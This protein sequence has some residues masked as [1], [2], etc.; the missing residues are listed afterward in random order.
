MNETKTSQSSRRH[1]LQGGAT[2]AG[3]AIAANAIATPPAVHAA[4]SDIL[5]VGLV[6]CGGRGTGAANNALHADPHVKLV[7]V[8]DAFRGQAENC[9]RNLKNSTTIADK[10]TVDADHVFVGLDAYQA[11]IDTVDVV[12]LCSP[13]GFRPKH[14]RAAV[15]AGCHI[16]TEKPMA[17]DSPGVRSVIES[18]KLSKEKNLSV[19]AGFCWRYSSPKL[20]FFD[21]IHAGEIGDVRASYGTYLGGPVKPMPSADT[22][23]SGMTD[24]EWMIHNWYNFAWLSGDGLVEQACHTVDWIAWTMQDTHPV[25]CTALGGRQIPTEGGN[26]YDHVEVNYLW[27]NGARS[28]LSQRQ[29]A[30]CYG[31]NNLYVLGTEG[32]ASLTRNTQISDLNGETTWKYKGPNPDMYQVEHNE[33]FASIRS[34]NPMN[35]GERMVNSTMMSIMGRMAGYSGDQITWEMALNSPQ[36]LAPE[37]IT[38]WNSPVVFRGVPHPGTV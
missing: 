11:V 14:L 15:D 1:F 36:S 26:I 12:L 10:V 29:I 5:K 23:P 30:G 33:L 24:L 18:V 6:G 13:P 27:A 37:N 8:G 34:G 20:A 3:T 32:N 28:F 17:T 16:F 4:G 38:D 7:A 22:R 25:S 35:H 21:R 19:V 31:E 9:L 2:V